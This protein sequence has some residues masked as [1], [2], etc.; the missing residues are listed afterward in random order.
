MSVAS[1]DFVALPSQQQLV[2]RLLQLVGLSSSFIFLSG[3]S[4][5]GRSVVSQELMASLDAR[6][7]ISF[8][9][10][11][12][13]MNLAR[14]R[15][16]LILQLAPHAVFDAAD[17]L[18]ESLS[19]MYPEPQG[20]HLLVIDNVDTQNEEG[21][22]TELWDWMMIM[23]HHCPEHQISI[24][25]LC[26]PELANI[27]VHQLTGR[28]SPA[29]DIEIEA[30]TLKEQKNLLM[31]YWQEGYSGSSEKDNALIQLK[32]SQGTPGEIVSI[33]EAC[34]DK[35]TEG[36]TPREGHTP[37]TVHS[38][39]RIAAI[40]AVCAG[41]ALLLS[42]V[43]PSLMKHKTAEPA[44][45][46]ERQ[47]VEAAPNLGA[48]SATAG[49]STGIS[50]PGVGIQQEGISA[51]SNAEGVTAV[52]PTDDQ[53][54]KR[55]VISDHV[56]DQMDSSKPVPDQAVTAAQP[57]PS[58]ATVTPTPDAAVTGNG[59][60]VNGVSGTDANRVTSLQQMNPI[61]NEI[62]GDSQS[63][64][65]SSSSVEHKVR[66]HAPAHPKVS[67]KPQVKKPVPAAKTTV[68]KPAVKTKAKAV[69]TEP[70]IQPYAA[71]LGQKSTVMSSSVAPQGSGFTLQLAASSQP[72]SLKAMAQKNGLG[73]RYQVYKS[74]VTGMYVLIYGHYASAASAKADVVNL[75]AGIQQTK[76]WPKSNA[77]VQ[78]EQQ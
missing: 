50:A 11:H 35:S 77:Q 46:P 8:A 52:S 10:L 51:T 36:N 62:K 65:A 72:G 57:T 63:T 28:N 23:D 30:L 69:P 6:W 14:I 54:K 67:P 21:W 45:Q 9:S 42:L 41:I 20:P 56:I 12:P 58:A 34:M 61:V 22:I 26:T 17:P 31:N 4:G 1:T 59:S 29:L 73:S 38:V 15:E 3:P 47:A 78:K 76:P 70:V 24:L 33:A 16:M 32:Q 19:R 43:I 60:S 48:V 53:D 18:D 39:N 25:L 55:V 75:P 49:A 71:T 7:Q 66:H 44:T 64:L 2:S 27:Y 68:A 40:V 5:S 74:H 13:E 37:R